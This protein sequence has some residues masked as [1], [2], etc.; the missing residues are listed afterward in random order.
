MRKKRCL[1]RFV[2]LAVLFILGI[3]VRSSEA[4]FDGCSIPS[5]TDKPKPEWAN[6]GWRKP[7]FYVGVGRVD[8][9][10]NTEEW[11]HAAEQAAINN[12]SRTISVTV[13]S[14]FK[15]EMRQ[16]SKEYKQKFEQDIKQVVE[17][18]VKEN[19]RGVV[20]TDKW[21]DKDNCVL[22]AVAEISQESVESTRKFQKVTYY[23]DSAGDLVKKQN[24]KVALEYLKDAM[25]LLDGINFKYLP[26]AG[27]KPH[28]QS[29]LEREIDRLKG[30]VGSNTEKTLVSPLNVGKDVDKT[31]VEKVVGTIK[32]KMKRGERLLGSCESL[33][34]C[35][36]IASGQGYAHLA[37][38]KV[39]QQMTQSAS[40]SYKGTLRVEVTVYDAAKRSVLKGPAEE[41]GQV[42]GWSE[43]S[44]DWKMAADKVLAS[45]RLNLMKE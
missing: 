18:S 1:G 25:A 38:V 11:I 30:D 15:D 36:D 39:E 20:I 29:K 45:D 31:I 6:D 22:W 5:M 26:D 4:F 33:D 28:W 10:R 32:A 9:R 19:L 2:I 14:S 21:L 44:I 27:G 35:L 16:T 12:L 41:Y 3:G 23:Y 42:V 17:T 13:E 34:T 37:L 8:K 43:E 7:G 24:K 40:G